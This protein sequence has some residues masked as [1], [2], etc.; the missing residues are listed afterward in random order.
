MPIEQAFEELHRLW[1]HRPLQS[2]PPQLQRMMRHTDI[3]A[4]V[5]GKCQN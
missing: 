5:M 4:G 1:R 3:V 2:C